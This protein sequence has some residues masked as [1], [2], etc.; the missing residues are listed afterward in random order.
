MN[1]PSPLGQA[2]EPTAPRLWQTI[3][4]RALA[5]I[6]HGTIAIEGSS[7]A[8]TLGTGEPVARLRVHDPACF[9]RMVQGGTV[10]AGESYM[11][12]HWDSDELVD[13]VRIMLQNREAL[14][15]LE[16]FAAVP[17]AVLDGLRHLLRRNSRAG[18][19]RNIREHYDLGNEFFRLFLDERMMYSAAVYDPPDATLDA[20]SVAKLER[21][22]RKLQLAPGDEVLEI[23]TGWG[24]FAVYAAE[25]H[26]CHVTTATISKSQ[27]QHAKALVAARGLAGK[28]NVLLAD[29]R[30]LA[31][32]YD[33]LVSVEMV[34]AV[35]HA[36]LDRYFDA[37]ARLLR[38][39]G[40]MVL[41]AIV[42]RDSRYRRAL[43][44]ADFIKKHIFPGG[45]IPSIS[46]LT[47]AAAR[48]DLSVANLEDFA[49]DYALTLR[50]WRRRLDA[51]AGEARALGFDER[52]LRKWRFYFAYCEGGFRER[53]ISDVQIVYTKSDYRGRVWRA[54]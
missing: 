17:A 24:G 11:A 43:H 32:S 45:F 54:S 9:R 48:A 29:Y 2:A 15:T 39:D 27:Y 42:I 10:G 12:G 34:E 21:L 25:T 20:A 50:D 41:Q 31:G 7:G 35:G 53:A 18:S 23:G 51:N 36:F 26:G 14:A 3:A 6:R 33:K 40:L 22:C 38:G 30:D 49:N 16:G 5:G 28:V 47:T 52:F 4:E 44:K 19:R 8:S 37:A 1:V 46:A 13:L